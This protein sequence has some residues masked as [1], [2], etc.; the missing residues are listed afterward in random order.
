MSV[1]RVATNSQAQ[2]LL[3]R[4]MQA[5]QS[6]SRTQQQVSSGKI[7]DNYGGINDKTAALEAARAAAERASAYATNTQLSL[8][9]TD[10]QDTQL[11][12]LSGLAQQLKDALTSAAGNADGTSLMVTAQSVFEQAASILNATDSNGNYIYGGQ[13]TDTKPF[14]AT[15][16][17]ELAGAPVSS[18]FVNGSQKKTV[19]VGDGQTEQIGILASDIGTNLMNAL[20][21]LYQQDTPSGSLD[22]Q[23]T[24]SQVD[25][26]TSTVVPLANQATDELN[27]AAAANGNVYKSL[28]DAITHQQ[29]LSTLY[30]GFV[31]DIEDV[32]MA[33]ALTNLTQD[34]IALQAALTVAARLG[35]VSLLNYL[36]VL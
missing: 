32:D 29:S 11:T 25:G 8:T 35:Q 28:K 6:L 9:Q 7:S 26:L 1:E 4:I 23:L 24:S 12:N 5:N 14:T 17:A 31:S 19:Q 3:A 27:A 16:L 21:T 30:G 33:Q 10:L 2:Y 34:Q 18:F 22:G 15:S 36:P 20:R 13:K